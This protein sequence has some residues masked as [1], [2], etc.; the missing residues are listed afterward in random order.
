MLFKPT[1][2]PQQERAA[3]IMTFKGLSH[4]VTFM[5]PSQ[6]AGLAAQLVL[7]E[8]KSEKP[9]RAVA[10]LVTGASPSNL[11]KA[12][13]A[14]ADE[15]TALVAGKL[16]IAGI[17]CN[18]KPQAFDVVMPAAEPRMTVVE[19]PELSS[20][21]VKSLPL[22]DMPAAKPRMTMAKFLSTYQALTPAERVAFGRAIGVERVWQPR[23]RYAA[24]ALA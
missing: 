7:Q 17:K 15:R 10:A 6:R 1:V 9:T 8:T 3:P 23:Q 12:L 2:P 13:K 18:E 5:S 19:L 24:P 21:H 20:D 4:R 14:T 22:E 11:T 16:T